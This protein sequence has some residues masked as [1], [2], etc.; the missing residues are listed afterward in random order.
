MERTEKVWGIAYTSATYMGYLWPSS[1]QGHLRVIQCNC[2]KV[3]CSSKRLW[4][5]RNGLHLLH[6]LTSDQAER[7]GP[8]ATC[9]FYYLWMRFHKWKLNTWLG[10]QLRLFAWLPQ[11]LLRTREYHLPW[12]PGIH[13]E[14]IL[15]MEDFMSPFLWCSIIIFQNIC[16]LYKHILKTP[17]I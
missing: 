4:M 10:Q 8:W 15:N 2:V 5:E 13:T 14:S 9:T 7:Q 6:S 12:V 17:H 1:V 11:K 16:T 3:A